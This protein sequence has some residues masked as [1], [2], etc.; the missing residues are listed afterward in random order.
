[1]GKSHRINYRNIRKNCIFI[2][3]RYSKK[4]VN[5]QVILNKIRSLPDSIKLEILDFIEFLTQKY[6]KSKSQKV[7]PKYGSL[8]GT[9]KISNDLDEP[10]DDF[11]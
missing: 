2:A 7:I 11:S 9:F 10:L 3:N 6:R 4:M 5:D 8:K 1:M